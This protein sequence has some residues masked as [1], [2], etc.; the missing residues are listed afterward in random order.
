MAADPVISATD[1]PPPEQLWH[2]G[3]EKPAGP[4]R[5]L[6]AAEL[7]GIAQAGKELQGILHAVDAEV[8]LGHPAKRQVKVRASR[9]VKTWLFESVNA[10]SSVGSCARA[11]D[12]V[13]QNAMINRT[14]A[15]AHFA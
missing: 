6:V 3:D 9:V 1:G 8:E 7:V 12:A 2:D 10:A 13:D 14:Q 11:G 5:A 4:A 15:A